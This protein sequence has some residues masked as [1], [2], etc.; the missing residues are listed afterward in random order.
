M[1]Y[2]YICVIETAIPP[3]MTIFFHNMSLVLQ[4]IFNIDRFIYCIIYQRYIYSKT[5]PA[6]PKN[7]WPIEQQ[8][9]PK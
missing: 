7:N 5:F 1:Y 8:F 6:N 9:D 2:R 4:N 3:A